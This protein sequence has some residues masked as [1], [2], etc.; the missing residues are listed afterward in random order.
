[1][2]ITNISLLKPVCELVLP[3]EVDDL[4]KKLEEELLNSKDLGFPGVG[5]ACPQIGIPKS[6]AIVRI[7][8]FKLN[9]VNAK[10]I[11]KYHPFIFD[12]EG[13]LSFP[14]LFIQT[15][16]YREIVVDNNLV[17]PYKFIITDFAAV[18]VQH[19]LDHLNQV[20]LPDLA[21]PKPL[22]I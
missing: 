22:S 12:G 20:L 15:N 13:C 21:I 8:D 17:K 9:L 6:L 1:M 18:V 4:I 16:R 2:I 5:L 3:E 14:N 19:E 11:E 7:G 10:I